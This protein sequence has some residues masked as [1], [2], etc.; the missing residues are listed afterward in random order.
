MTAGVLW[1]KYVMTSSNAHINIKSGLLLVVKS[2]KLRTV[3]A[4]VETVFAL[5][6]DRINHTNN[7]I[8]KEKEM[9]R[10]LGLTLIAM[11]IGMLLVFLLPGTAFIV[12]ASIILMFLGYIFILK[13]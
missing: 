5:C 11:G 2:R 8:R 4:Y 10:V 1:Y 13:Y 12:I 7:K 3:S 6:I 9:K